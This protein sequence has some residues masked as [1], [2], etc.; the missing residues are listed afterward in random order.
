MRNKS[1]PTIIALIGAFTFSCSNHKNLTRAER[2]QT[3]AVAR[4]SQYVYRSGHIGWSKGYNPVPPMKRSTW[5][6][7]RWVKTSQGES[8]IPGYRK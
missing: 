5:V 7:G 4:S 3:Q 8:W 6:P 2:I 1:I